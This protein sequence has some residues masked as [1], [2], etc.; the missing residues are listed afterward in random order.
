MLCS[1][2]LIIVFQSNIISLSVFT[3]YFRYS[4]H[5]GG[6]L[7]SSIQCC[8]YLLGANDPFEQ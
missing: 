5:S 6:L 2:I 1:E 7:L 4:F 8:F 3:Y